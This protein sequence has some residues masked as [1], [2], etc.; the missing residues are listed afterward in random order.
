MAI[1]KIVVVLVKTVVALVSREHIVS[2]Q[3]QAVFA[4]YIN[5]I[6]SHGQLA[7]VTKATLIT[8]LLILVQTNHVNVAAIT[9]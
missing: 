2:W 5:A 7:K 6:R 4:W 8:S 3:M 1:V 9:A